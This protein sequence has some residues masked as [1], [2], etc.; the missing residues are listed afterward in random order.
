MRYMRENHHHGKDLCNISL[1]IGVVFKLKVVTGWVDQ[2][3]TN[4]GVRLDKLQSR[5]KNTVMIFDV[6][7]MVKSDF[8][9]FEEWCQ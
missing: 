3:A 8:A 5:I 4:K 2:D 9:V 6:V 1:S 7:V